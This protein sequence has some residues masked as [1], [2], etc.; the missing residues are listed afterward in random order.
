MLLLFFAYWQL[1]LVLNNSCLQAPYFFSKF[2]FFSKSTSLN[3]PTVHSERLGFKKEYF[4]GFWVPW[5]HFA[6]YKDCMQW[7]ILHLKSRNTLQNFWAYFKNAQNF[8][9]TRLL[10][11]FCI[12]SVVVFALDVPSYFDVY[13]LLGN[14]LIHISCVTFR[15]THEPSFTLISVHK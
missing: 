11:S 1:A 9:P 7:L 6:R 2:L 15:S 10:F 8:V 14:V 3:S 13:C 5:M 12:H 4:E